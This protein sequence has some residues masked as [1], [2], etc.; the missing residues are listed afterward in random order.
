MDVASH[1][2]LI[3]WLYLE[4]LYSQGR[5]RGSG[6]MEQVA[7]LGTKL[8]QCILLC[9]GHGLLRNGIPQNPQKDDLHGKPY[10]QP[11]N[12]CPQEVLEV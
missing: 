2:S 4:T 1:S 5:Q 12:T 11:A 10:F 7:R 8:Q 6:L 9:T 3:K